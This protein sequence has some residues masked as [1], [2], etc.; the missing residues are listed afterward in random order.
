M[1][2]S[3]YEAGFRVLDISNRETPV[4]VAFFDT[5]PNGGGASWSNYPYFKSGTI[6][7]TGG[8]TGL[9]IVRKKEVDI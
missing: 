6:V 4:E 2:E 5:D 3:N 1:Y 8:T 9:F 7:V